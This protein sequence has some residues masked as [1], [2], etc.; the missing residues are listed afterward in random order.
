MVAA[1]TTASADMQFLR[2]VVAIRRIA[3]E[4][5]EAGFYP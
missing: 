5:D 4:A 2:G 3:A 1:S